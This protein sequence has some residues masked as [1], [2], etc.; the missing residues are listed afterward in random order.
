MVGILFS[1]VAFSG[2]FESSPKTIYVDDDGTADYTKI[3]D[4]L[5]QAN[6]GDT[7]IVLNGTYN[8][9]LIIT[10]SIDLIGTRKGKT[11]LNCQDSSELSRDILIQINADN[12]TIDGFEILGCNDSS[13]I[14]AINVNSSNNII[15]NI[16]I[17]YFHKGISLAEESKNNSISR[18]NI[19]NNQY[20]IYTRRA[21]STNISHNKFFSNSLYGIYFSI[22]FDNII[23]KNNFTDNNYGIR[24]KGSD[25]NLVVGNLIV[26]NERG[27]LFCCQASDNI[28]YYN[29]FKQNI[30]YNA[31]DEFTNNWDNG[32][33]GNYWDDYTAE[34]PDAL[35]IDG[36]WNIPYNISGGDN[37]DRYPL[38]N[39]AYN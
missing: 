2:C 14:I 15:S 12:C 8:E 6:D 16:S 9:I 5:A 22:S 36:I 25:N 23:F 26:M 30:E 19:S 31:R 24:I 37:Q 35:E 3:S 34:Y 10:R 4:A 7:V 33:I 28:A 32:H 18:N 38:I 1:T 29:A 17:R 27:L 20:G 11:I 13:E 39:S 21:F